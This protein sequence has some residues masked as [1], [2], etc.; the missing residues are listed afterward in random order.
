MAKCA[1]FWAD[2]CGAIAV[3]WVVITAAVVG[4]AMAVVA[5]TSS[6][7]EVLSS[8]VASEM[9]TRDIRVEPAPPPISPQDQLRATVVSFSNPEGA[10]RRYD[11]FA[12]PMQTGDRR[13]RNIHR[14]W[15]RRAADPNY[16]RPD[17]A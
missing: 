9:E 11:R 10:V 2:D 12:D 3:D 17:R 15:A 5:T 14:T 1:G 16:A 6:G 8:D 13:L 7:V 4:L